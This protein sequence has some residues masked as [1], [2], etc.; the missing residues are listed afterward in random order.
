MISGG[1]IFQIMVEIMI[2]RD[3]AFKDNIVKLE[4]GGALYIERCK[5]ITIEDNSNFTSNHAIMKGGAIYAINNIELV[6]IGVRIN[7]NY[8]EFSGGAIFLS[9][10]ILIIM[11]I[12]KA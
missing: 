9:N 3:T 7:Q 8:V 11:E 12:V 5:T 1:S 10:N 2:I 4:N 6:M